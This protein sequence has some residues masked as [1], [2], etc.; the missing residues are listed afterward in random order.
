MNLLFSTSSDRLIKIFQPESKNIIELTKLEGHKDNVNAVLVDEKNLLLFSCG[1]DPDIK[2]WDLDSYSLKDII[3]TGEGKMGCA[4]LNIEERNCIGVSFFTG[5]IRFYNIETKLCIFTLE[6]GVSNY[7]I[8]SLLY[9]PKKKFI[10]AQI[11]SKEIKIWKMINEELNEFT[12][13]GTIKSEGHANFVYVDKKEESIV[14]ACD[15]PFLDV[16][17]LNSLLRKNKIQFAETPLKNSNGL[18]LI[19]SLSKII[20]SAWNSPH[21]YILKYGS[22]SV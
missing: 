5:K 19:P 14:F 2:I 10:I 21:L 7:Y 22:L 17:D 18:L 16:F 11:S 6:T 1:R 9:L 20:V 15:K 13:Y 8:N 3:S 12:V 4:I